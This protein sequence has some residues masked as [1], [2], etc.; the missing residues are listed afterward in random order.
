MATTLAGH[1]PHHLF[2]ALTDITVSRAQLASNRQVD[3]SVVRPAL[4]VHS[5]R[6]QETIC[7]GHVYNARGWQSWWWERRSV[8]KVHKGLF[9]VP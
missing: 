6:K 2:H 8:E 1:V 3:R 4:L 7:V 5:R 9:V